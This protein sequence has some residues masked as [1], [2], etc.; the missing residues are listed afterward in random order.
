MDCEVSGWKPQ[1]ECSKSCGGGVQ[2]MQRYIMREP[3]RNGKPC[4]E[5]H[6]EVVCNQE[7]C[8]SDCVVGPWTP[9]TPCSNPCGGGLQEFERKI[10]THPGG[11]GKK[12]PDLSSRKLCNEMPCSLVGSS[13][14]SN[15][16]M[17]ANVDCEMSPWTKDGHCPCGGGL[18]RFKRH[19]LTHQL[20]MGSSC[21]ESMKEETC[22]NTTC[23]EQD[24]E[25]GPWLPYGDCTVPCGGGHQKFVRG[26]TTPPVGKERKCPE[27]S[28]MEPCNAQICVNIEC[29]LSS[30]TASGTCT[31]GKQSFL[32][33]VIE[34]PRGD[35]LPCPELVKTQPCS[36]TGAIK[37]IDC[38][39]SDWSPSGDCSLM[40]G[41]GEQTFTRQVL[42]AP[43]DH[44]KQCPKLE[45]TRKCNAH[46]CNEGCVVGEWKTVG[47]CDEPCGGGV[48][49]YSREVSVKPGSSLDR[50][51]CP[52]DA[53]YE[54]CNVQ[55]CDTDCVVGEWKME[56]D[57]E[58]SAPCGGG[59]LRHY[60]DV[61]VPAEGLGLACPS[62]HMDKECNEQSCDGCQY[63]DWTSTS[64]CSAECGGGTQS[65]SREI[66][67]GES[68]GEELTKTEICNEIDCNAPCI[69]GEWELEGFCTHPCGGGYKRKVRE[70]LQEPG[71][72]GNPC[73]ELFEN[74]GQCNPQAC[75]SKENLAYCEYHTFCNEDD[76][77][78]T[79]SHKCVAN[80]WTKLKELF[81]EEICNEVNF[82]EAEID[83]FGIDNF[84][85]GVRNATSKSLI[86]SKNGI[87]DDMA[88]KLAMEVQGLEHLEWLDLEFNSITDKGAYALALAFQDNEHFKMRNLH[89]S[90]KGNAIT[91]KGKKYL[92]G[93]AAKLLDEGRQL[94]LHF[95]GTD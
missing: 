16:E 76:P 44:G 78:E 17:P 69:L 4:G 55:V 20:G 24:C 7:E 28:K 85:A 8:P 34:A 86:L 60:R 12:C 88:I 3:V 84:N 1:G 79:S 82:M 19:V 90:L 13:T 32:R 66:V 6:K 51:D 50:D 33:E 93:V 61:L 87:D 92:A 40:C 41:G 91:E 25:V 77:D 43:N 31:D 14:G 9:K 70:V 37:A 80:S 65:Y 89:I 5:L 47:E 57:G 67:S 35:V 72:E 73:G 27:L 26:V 71:P 36:G 54:E 15:L 10:L 45:D 75:P 38:V 68:C 48:L 63:T 11:N 81:G 83:K 42:E 74:L 52:E 39:V 94:F 30:W 46:E 18:Q 56:G 53:K 22:S 29:K 95:S 21:G 64:G 2:M 23:S 62:L 58:C 49:T 59:V